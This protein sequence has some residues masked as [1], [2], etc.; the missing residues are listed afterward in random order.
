MVKLVPVLLGLLLVAGRATAGEKEI[1][2]E[3]RKVGV[4]VVSDSGQ[5][6]ALFFGS[7]TANETDFV[8]LCELQHLYAISFDGFQTTPGILRKVG[9]LN[10]V[11]YLHLD[12][13]PVTDRDLAEF[14]GMKHLKDLGLSD[15]TVT[16]AGLREV[17]NLKTLRTLNLENTNVTDAGVAELQKALPKC[18][19]IR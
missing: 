9:L 15:T 6:L 14:R 11:E 3:L 13:T 19:I 8:Y 2:E 7:S 10:Q 18:H 5:T 17:A 1:T 16:D 12:K 4:M